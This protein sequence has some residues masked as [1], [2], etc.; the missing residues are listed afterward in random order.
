LVGE[1][2]QAT[3][4]QFDLLHKDFQATRQGQTALRQDLCGADPKY[5]IK[6]RVFTELAGIPCS[7]RT[8]LIRPNPPSRRTCRT[9]ISTCLRSRPIPNHGVRSDRG[10]HRLHPRRMI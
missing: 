8:L 3:P 6:A 9:A 1:E 10:R 5:R 4:A 2:R 7:V